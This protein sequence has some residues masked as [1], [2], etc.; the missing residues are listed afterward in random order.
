MNFPE[1]P[2]W[3]IIWSATVI[4]PSFILSP[5][6]L[7]FVIPALIFSALAIFVYAVIAVLGASRLRL[8]AI[9]AGRAPIAISARLAARRLYQ[10]EKFSSLANGFASRI[11]FQEIA[12]RF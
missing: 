7:A 1:A 6:L 10:K 2:R 8:R 11:E 3:S 12:N 5:A 4:S 9:F